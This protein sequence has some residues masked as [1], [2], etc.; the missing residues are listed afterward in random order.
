MTA[1]IS[2]SPAVRSL[3]LQCINGVILTLFLL[4]FFDVTESAGQGDTLWVVGMWMF[5][6]LMSAVVAWRTPIPTIKFGWLDLSVAVLVAGHMISGVVVACSN[7]EKRLAVNLA[8]EWC[9][10]GIGWFLLRQSLSQTGFRRDLLAGLVAVGT[11]TA[12]LGLYQHYVEFP[13]LVARYGPLFDQLRQASEIEKVTLRKQLAKDNIPT[14]GAA[15][16]LFEKRLRDSREPLGFFALANSFG[17]L[18]AVCLL[19]TAIYATS[20]STVDGP[21][22]WRRR[23]HW[24]VMAA[25]IGWCLVLTKNR[26]AWIGAM[27]GIAVWGLSVGRVKRGQIRAAVVGAI[28]VATVLVGGGLTLIGGLDRQVITEAPKSLQ[29]RLHYWAA[30]WAML[31]DHPWLGVGLGQFRSQYLQYK[32]PEA[33]EEIA[34]PHNLFLDVAANGGVIAL[35]GLIG[36]CV[37]LMTR[38]AAGNGDNST[39]ELHADSLTLYI[40]ATIAAAGWGV[41]LATGYD[42]R[43]LIV[44][45]LVL[46]FFA[47]L[48]R[49]LNDSR[50]NSRVELLAALSA[51]FVLLAHCAAQGESECRRSVCCCWQWSRLWSRVGPRT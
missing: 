22:R 50:I 37:V 49:M 27:A 15:V 42:D 31:R 23:L 2:R 4:R 45:P 5:A 46:G 6:L 20:V 1:R 9:G 39:D 33:S 21:V 26:T 16:I 48:R 30:T 10:I 11:V 38:I 34:D 44:L 43:L 13:R 24:I 47:I 41:A 12:G 32:L 3:P 17:G 8:W 51:A 36:I 18:L 25:V 40:V 19:V 28:L 14:D 35:L 7:G 29:Y